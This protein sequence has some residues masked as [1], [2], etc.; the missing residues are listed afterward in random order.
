MIFSH[1]TYRRG[2]PSN[3][4]DK[5]REAALRCQRT[6]FNDNP[7][8]NSSRNSFVATWMQGAP[9]V[10]L[11]KPDAIRPVPRSAIIPACQRAGVDRN[12]TRP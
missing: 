2:D 10:E 5:K 3:G 1:S 4:E 9:G 6:P 12:G 8:P 11:R 7:K